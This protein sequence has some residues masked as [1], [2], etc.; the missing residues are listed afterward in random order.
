VWHSAGGGGG[1]FDTGEG[2]G[3]GGGA[4]AVLGVGWDLRP[5]SGRL[6]VTPGAE[7]L[8]LT[9]FGAS[10]TL[11]LFTVGIGLN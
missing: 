9:D 4:A 2:G 3:A 6:R 10:D 7:V 5:G 8:V 1:V 11:L